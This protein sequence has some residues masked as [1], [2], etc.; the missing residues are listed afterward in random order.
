MRKPFVVSPW[1]KCSTCF[2]SIDFNDA[3]IKGYY[4]G[5]KI[6]TC[7]QGHTTD[8]WNLIKHGIKDNFMDNQAYTFIGAETKV[9]TICLQEGQAYRYKFS[10]YGIPH[11][12]KVLYINYTSQGPGLF[13]IEMHG[14]VST[15]RSVGNEV[16]VYPVP[17]KLDSSNSAQTDTK[18]SVMV[19]WVP[20]TTEDGSLYSLR[21][22]FDF[23]MQDNYL[24]VIIPANVAVELAVERL[25][26]SYFQNFSSKTKADKFMKEV[27]YEHQL[28]V[29]L[30]M[31]AKREGL[32]VLPEQIWD[33]L[34]KLRRNRNNVAHCG[35]LE[36]PFEKDEAARLL[37]GSLFGLHYMKYLR[38]QLLGNLK[39]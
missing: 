39:L 7:P 1:I 13:P 32:P 29:L 10:D 36:K 22:A 38:E 30:P 12:A 31:I 24:S 26:T 23:Y 2:A 27:T 19:S 9:F 11:D 17:T 34:N 4:K 15:R 37:C 25:L 5:E 21:E 28:N 14:N 20:S 8:W 16:V 33:E 6:V 18:V 35:K 3:Q